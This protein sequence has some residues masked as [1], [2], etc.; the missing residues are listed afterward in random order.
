MFRLDKFVKEGLIEN[1]VDLFKQLKTKDEALE[2]ALEDQ[3]LNET[4]CKDKALKEEN[5]LA[6]QTLNATLNET[7]Y[8][9]FSAD[10]SLVTEKPAENDSRLSKTDEGDLGIGL[11]STTQIEPEVGGNLK[12]LVNDIVSCTF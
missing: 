7:V 8:K 2:N 11:K 6:D 1:Q 4:V 12:L 10:E 3:I 9:S 5:A